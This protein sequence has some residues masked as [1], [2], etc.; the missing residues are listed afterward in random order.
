MPFFYLV[1]RAWSHWR[2]YSGS[3]HIQFLLKN[4]LAIPRPS[5]ILDTLYA[6]GIMQN[7]RN[8]TVISSK[9][10]RGAEASLKAQTLAENEY[11]VLDKWNA[12]LI[13]KAL[14]VP[15]LEVELERAIWQVEST[16]KATE[17]LNEEKERLE[18]STRQSEAQEQEQ[19]KK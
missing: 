13:A 2:A 7:V 10:V 14:A 6:A 16:L 11:L 17:L 18:K 19:E 9:T 3:K 8:G 15:E 12:A 5:P 4:N 1:Y